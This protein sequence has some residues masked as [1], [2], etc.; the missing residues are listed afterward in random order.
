MKDIDTSQILE[1]ADFDLGTDCR[2]ALESIHD[3]DTQTE[4]KV[5][6]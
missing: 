3:E 2:L 1:P 6:Y 5:L 4:R